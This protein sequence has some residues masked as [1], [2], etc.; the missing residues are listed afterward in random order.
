MPFRAK[1]VQ[2]SMFSKRSRNGDLVHG[3]SPFYAHKSGRFS[4]QNAPPTPQ[5]AARTQ[6]QFRTVNPRGGVYEILTKSVLL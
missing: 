1:S 3:V 5:I 2:M 6:T 4:M